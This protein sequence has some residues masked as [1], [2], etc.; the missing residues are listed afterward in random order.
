MRILLQHKGTGLYLRD[1]DAWS[2][3][4]AEAMDFVSSTAALDFC[5]A[6]RMDQVQ[7]VLRFEEEKHD[8]VLPVVPDIDYRARPRP[9]A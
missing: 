7:L 2:G 4:S 6:N 3:N 5:A 1:G 9:A 8:I